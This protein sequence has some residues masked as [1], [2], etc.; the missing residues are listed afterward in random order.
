MSPPEPVS[1]FPA[2]GS[3]ALNLSDTVHFSEGSGDVCGRN[4][5]PPQ[6]Q[7]FWFKPRTGLFFMVFLVVIFV[8]AVLFVFVVIFIVVVFVVIAISLVFTFMVH[9]HML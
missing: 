4:P 1:V 6:A 9:P 2:T 7:K 3:D 5:G 8:V